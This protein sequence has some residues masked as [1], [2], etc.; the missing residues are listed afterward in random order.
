MQGFFLA[1]VTWPLIY[2]IIATLNFG[3]INSGKKNIFIAHVIIWV[4]PYL[5][6]RVV[7]A[8]TPRS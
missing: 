2:L 3:S 4:I 8:V 1:L 6:V 7:L 5:E